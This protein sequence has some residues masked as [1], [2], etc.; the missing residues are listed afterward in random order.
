[1]AAER[2]CHGMASGQREAG[3]LFFPLVLDL[4]VLQVYRS[5]APMFFVALTKYLTR[6]NLWGKA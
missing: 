1:M 5:Q 4:Q 3:K 2:E 6:T